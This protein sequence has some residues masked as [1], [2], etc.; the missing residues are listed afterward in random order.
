MANTMQTPVREGQV[1][2]VT[3]GHG[4][5]VTLAGYV[6]AVKKAKAHPDATFKEGLT[7][8]WPVTG[9]QIVRQF[10]DGMHD[11]INQRGAA[12]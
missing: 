12:A 8:W 10:R 3:L 1:R 7:C 2:T 5:V 4:K 11:R 6:K 9:E